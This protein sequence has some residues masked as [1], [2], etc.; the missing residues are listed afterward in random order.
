MVEKPQNHFE[1]FVKAGVKRLIYHAEG[2]PHLHR[3]AQQIRDLGASPGI[4][5]NPGTPLDILDEVLPYV[6]M[7]LLMTV[8]PGWGGQ[9][10]I[11][12]MFDKIRRLRQRIDAQG[13]PMDLEGDGGGNASTIADTTLGASPVRFSK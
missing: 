4:V 6:D 11:P 8:N 13:R 10:L 7:V 5:L 3:L 1:A 12:S 2:N 9:K